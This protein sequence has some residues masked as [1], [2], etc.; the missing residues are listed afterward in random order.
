MDEVVTDENRVRAL[1][2][3]KRN[4]GSAG[5]DGM[6]TTEL[7]KH[8]QAHLGKDPGEAVGGHL[9]SQPGEAGRDTEAERGHADVR[10]S[11][12]QRELHQSA[13]RI[14]DGRRFAIRSIRFAAS[15]SRF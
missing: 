13:I 10:D 7:E 11:D 14:W 1:E 8:L 15:A 2:A 3:V 4:R 12:G 5:I 9:R 6:K